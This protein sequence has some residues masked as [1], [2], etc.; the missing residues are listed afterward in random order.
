M[1]DEDTQVPLEWADVLE[2]NISLGAL[3][4]HETLLGV[5]SHWI[6]ME[7][8]P[9]EE[10]TETPRRKWKRGVLSPPPKAE[11]K[12]EPSQPTASPLKIKP[13]AAEK[14]SKSAK[15]VKVREDSR[16]ANDIMDC[17]LARASTASSSKD[18]MKKPDPASDTDVD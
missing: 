10:V 14:V 11:L 15:R 1:A 18:A 13:A 6:N 9:I 3:R 7:D 17:Y 16:K 2:H 4:Q 8:D 5:F 12:S